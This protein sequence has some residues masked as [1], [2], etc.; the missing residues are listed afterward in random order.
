VGTT[1]AT[2]R[3][4]TGRLCGDLIVATATANGTTTT[5]IDTVRAVA[6][7][8]ALIGRQAFYVS[9]TS[10]NLYTTRRVSANA[11]STGT[12]TV[13]TAWSSAS[14]SGDV[15]EL[16][17]SRSISPTPDE[18]HDKLNDLI[19]GVADKHLTVVDSTPATF[20]AEDPYLD[21]PATWIGY[22]G[23][24][25][26]DDLGIWHEI[27][28]A[29]RPL[30]KNLGTYGQV[31]IA[32][33]TRWQVD[34]NDVMLVGVTPAAV[35]ASDTDST[36]VNPDWLCKQAAGELLIQNARSYE[37]TAGAERRGNLYLQL[38]AALFPQVQTRPPANF[39][40]LNRT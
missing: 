12:I 11:E 35:L 5:L 8:D 40:R 36:I 25:W 32:G 9:G 14:A 7:D 39:Q 4:T 26:Q 21:I 23:A 6:G 17:A 18:I 24:F 2:L 22:S 1:R 15:V 34:G 19:R 16:F 20:D 10:A 28:K 30:H 29:H 27:A 13:S 3:R 37:D 31:E 33:T 38:A